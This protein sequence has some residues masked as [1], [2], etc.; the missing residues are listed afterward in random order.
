MKI[1]YTMGV[2]DIMK[3]EELQVVKVLINFNDE[4]IRAGDTGTVVFCF[5]K[6]SE[7][8]EVEFINDDGSTKAMFA[9]QS[10]YL[11]SV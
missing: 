3:F 1:F 9:I 8:Y 4:N 11:E 10:E 5:T 7:A 2:G 6:P